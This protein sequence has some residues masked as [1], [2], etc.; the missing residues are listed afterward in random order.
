MGSIA[1]IPS[2]CSGAV[3]VVEVT[4]NAMTVLWRTADT[5]PRGVSALTN[6]GRL[7]ARGTGLGKAR[8]LVVGFRALFF[9]L[10]AHY[11]V[12]AMQIIESVSSGDPLLKAPFE[13][14]YIRIA[15]IL[16]SERSQGGTATGT[17]VKNNSRI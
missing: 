10:I 14:H 7:E 1:H 5:Q 15:H 6:T 4:S 13:I 2:G 17:A 8:S 16:Q 11:S 3:A 9:L 12:F